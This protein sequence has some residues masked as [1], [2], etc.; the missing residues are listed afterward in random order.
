MRDCIGLQVILLNKGRIYMP[1]G[2]GPEGRGSLMDLQLG[3]KE[4]A[5][6]SK[7]LQGHLLEIQKNLSYLN[8][9]GMVDNPVRFAVGSCI[10]TIGIDLLGMV[11]DYLDGINL[12]DL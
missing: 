10:L 2:N 4:V 6:K 7:E 8:G 3:M 5:K 12:V 1:K 9:T 11:D